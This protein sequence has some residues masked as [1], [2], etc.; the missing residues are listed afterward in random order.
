MP[1]R[2]LKDQG[3]RVDPTRKNF[4]SLDLTRE[5]E[6]R[7]LMATT[8]TVAAKAAVEAATPKATAAAPA[9]AR[10]SPSLDRLERKAPPGAS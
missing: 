4:R 8:R 9:E 10:G 1:S 6:V 7:A 5:K 3:W 2:D